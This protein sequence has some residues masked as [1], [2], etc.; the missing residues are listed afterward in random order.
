MESELYRNQHYSSRDRLEIVGIP[1]NI[2]DTGVEKAA[3]NL[4]K[5]IDV[6]LEP[7]DI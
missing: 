6:V 5:K 7:R 2:L 1:E 4:F 3:M